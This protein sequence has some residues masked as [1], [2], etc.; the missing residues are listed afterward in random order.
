MFKA[1]LSLLKHTVVYGLGNVI[2]RLIAFI[3]LPVFTHALEPSGFGIYQLYYVAIGIVMEILRMGQDIALLRYYAL[4]KEQKARKII[5]STIFWSATAFSL[6]IG[7]ALWFGAEYWVRLI[8]EMPEPYPEWSIYTL[9]LCALIIAFDNLAA[10]PLV[11]IRVEGQPVRFS[12]IKLSGAV[13]Q[14]AASVWLVVSL[15]R[16]VAGIF[17]ANVLSAGLMLLL[18]LPTIMSRLAVA[19]DSAVFKAC[20]AFGLPN[21]PNSLFVVGISLADRKVLELYRGAAEM[22]IYSASYKLGMFLSIVA[23]GFRYAWQPFFLKSADQPDAQKLFARVMT[24][25]VAVT[26]WMFLLLTAFVPSL[27]KYDIPGVGHLI[28]KQYWA[29]LG[30]FPIV[31]SAYIFDGMYAIFM[32]GIY[33]KKKMHV[34]PFITGTAVIVNVGGNILLVPKYGMWAAAWLTVVS[35]ALMALLLYI[36]VNRQYPVKYEWGR[37]L[38]IGAMAAICFMG[39]IWGSNQGSLLLTFLPGLIF[40]ALLLLTGVANRQELARIGIK[41]K[42]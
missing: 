1:I 22:G 25:Y 23:M 10:F 16:G 9:K 27:V 18:C 30:V 7:A 3:L 19:F 6:A 37:L 13:A 26:L 28:D 31:L 24:Y 20:L 29:G 39:A 33:L 14:V 17:E 41:L 35:Y 4:E 5:F 38:H 8:V 2:S 21:V 32:V 40:P 42:E 34:L 11:V 36:Y 15:Q 12:L